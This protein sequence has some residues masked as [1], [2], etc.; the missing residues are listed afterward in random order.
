MWWYSDNRSYEV[1]RS[2]PKKKGVGAVVGH[3]KQLG[4]FYDDICNAVLGSSTASSSS[5]RSSSSNNNPFN[6]RKEETFSGKL[7]LFRHRRPWLWE[8]ERFAKAQRTRAKIVFGK[9][10]R[11]LVE[12]IVGCGVSEEH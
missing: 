9:N 4:K 3:E 11:E 1:E 6:R 8:G 5:S 2:I 7:Q 10:I 12:V